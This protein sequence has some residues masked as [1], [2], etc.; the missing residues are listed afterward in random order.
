MPV[1]YYHSAFSATYE[2]RQS[3]LITLCKVRNPFSSN[4][5]QDGQALWDTGAMGSVIG[6]KL[7]QSL[8]LTP[9]GK[10]RL[11]GIHGDETVNTYFVELALPNNVVF[12]KLNVYEANLTEPTNFL[13]G[14]EIIGTGDFSVCG[15]KLVS[16]CIP[17]FENPIDCVTKAE[18]VNKR[19]AKKNRQS[20][21]N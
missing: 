13:I 5:F 20:K 7:A 4:P 2:Q 17:P 9:T 3:A 11:G 16:Y 8:Q 1:K 12:Q 19:I 14:M 15:G 10:A 18:K 21:Q 6:P